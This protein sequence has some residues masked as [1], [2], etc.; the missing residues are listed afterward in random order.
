MLR[1]IAAGAIVLGAA[2]LA[3]VPVSRADDDMSSAEIESELVGRQIIW[4]EDGGWLTGRLTLG[5]NGAAEISVEH[6]APQAD[7][8]RWVLRDGELCT[9]WA[10]MRSGT[11][12]CYRVR[13]AEQGRFTTSG[14]NVF[15]IRDAGV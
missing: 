9:E 1:A 13:R 8:G 7:R 12:K 3:S 4:W 5:P 15:E 11:E 2:F 6:P 14:G 10:N